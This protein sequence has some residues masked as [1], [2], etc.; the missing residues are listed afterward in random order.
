MLNSDAKKLRTRILV[1]NEI[2]ALGTFLIQS[3]FCYKERKQN[4]IPYIC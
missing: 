2:I 1:K 4:T 3:F